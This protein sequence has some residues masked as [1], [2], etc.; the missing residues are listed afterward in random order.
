MSCSLEAYRHKVGVF[1]RTL[2]KSLHRKAK[3]A[4]TRFQAFRFNGRLAQITVVLVVDLNLIIALLVRAGNVRN[5]GPSVSDNSCVQ[6]NFDALCSA[7]DSRF[8]QT[9]HCLQRQRSELGKKID[10]E[11]EETFDRVG[12]ALQLMQSDVHTLQEETH[13]TR[14][15]IDH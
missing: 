7:F 15:D 3:I 4:A 2:G 5:P 9:M 8:T 14:T 1:A 12:R 10:L 6:Y 13:R 11:L